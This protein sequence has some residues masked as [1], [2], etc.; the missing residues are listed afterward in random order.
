MAS[1]MQALAI[2]DSTQAADV[3]IRRFADS[4]SIIDRESDQSPSRSSAQ[5]L[6]G[7]PITVKDNFDVAG[8]ITTAGSRLLAAAKPALTDAPV[9]ARLRAAGAVILGHTNMTEFAFSG[10]GINPH[11]GTPRNPA[12][13][14]DTHIPG[15]SSSGAAVSVALGITPVALGTDT[16]GSVRIPAAFCGLVGF[17]PTARHISRDG[18]LPLSTSLDSVGVIATAVA[19]CRTVFELIRDQPSDP[20]ARRPRPAL[21][22][23]RLAVVRGYVDEDIEPDVGNAIQ[24]FMQ[25]LRDAGA[26]LSEIRI[27]ELAAIPAMQAKGTLSA[28][29]AYAWHQTYLA[30]HG[31]MYDPR[32]RARIERG[33]SISAEQY[34]DLQEA[35]ATFARMFSSRIAPFDAVLWP[36]T[37]IS[38]PRLDA[39]TAAESYDRCNLRVLRNSTI[40]N[41][42]DGCAISLPC[43]QSTVP[44]GM[45][46]AARHGQDAHLLDVAEIIEEA[47][48]LSQPAGTFRLADFFPPG[49]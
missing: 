21:S 42:A 10:L 25:R 5:A 28:A 15:G 23:L 37:P 33:A 18:V 12:F 27:P 45:T 35:R 4:R 8:F 19:D 24:A 34:R 39:L 6:R 44:A 49:H 7:V 31:E 20:R 17:K 32:V 13:R 40:V 30:Q 9:V 1:L 36:T 11:Y 47:A 43:P 48:N 22:A 14:N 26:S 41:L 38:A 46:L 29:E 16:G 3:F 2:A